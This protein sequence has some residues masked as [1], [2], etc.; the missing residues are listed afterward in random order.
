MVLDLSFIRLVLNDFVSA[1][2]DNPN[3]AALL[4]D[5]FIQQ[6]TTETFVQTTNLENGIA[7]AGGIQVDLI[8]GCQNIIQNIDSN[9]AYSSFIDEN[10]KP[11]ITFEFGIIN[12]NYHNKPLYLKIKDLINDNIYYSNS[13]LINNNNKLST[14]F[15]YYNAGDTFKKSIRIS[16]CYYQTPVNN[17]DFKSYTTTSG[18]QVSYRQVTTYLQKFNIDNLDFFVNDRLYKLF[19]HSIIYVNSNRSS[20]SDY[21]ATERNGDTNFLTAEFTINKYNQIY[22]WSYQIIQP[23]DVISLDL[24][25]GTFITYAD[26]QSYIGGGLSNQMLIFFNKN[27]GYNIIPISIKIYKDNI[28]FKTSTDALVFE[29]QL[30]ILLSADI[31]DFTNGEYNIVIEP[32]SNLLGVETWQGITFGN[33]TFTISDGEYDNTEYNNSEY[34]IN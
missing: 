7:F 27:L 21:K 5:G 13:F 9:F 20:I 30:Q 23:L 12:T 33:W 8:D 32:I 22:N 6:L 11:Q 26:F 29:F 14:R 28:L 10:G 15:D 16:N 19:S 34:L 4:Y 18:Q 1:K 2:G 17:L 25:N 31:T 3:V 24:P